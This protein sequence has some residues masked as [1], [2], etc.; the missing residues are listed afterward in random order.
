MKRGHEI[1]TKACAANF[2]QAPDV[3]A[4]SRQKTRGGVSQ[5]EMAIAE[6]R[7]LS[8][9]AST[10]VID[11]LMCILSYHICCLNRASHTLI[12]GNN[13][14]LTT[15]VISV[16]EIRKAVREAVFVVNERNRK[17]YLFTNHALQDK[18]ASNLNHL[19]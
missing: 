14:S 3:R 2:A 8:M 19:I 12:I 16:F 9:M 4:C 5:R 11:R 1:Q 7:G 13:E 15:V 6:S 18:N 10:V 17:M